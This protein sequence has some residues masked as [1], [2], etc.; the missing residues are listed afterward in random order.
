[1][2]AGRLTLLVLPKRDTVPRLSPADRYRQYLKSRTWAKK[3]QIAINRS[4]GYC[5]YPECTSFGV[6]VHHLRYPKIWGQERPE[7][8]CYLCRAHHQDIHGIETEPAA[9]KVVYPILWD[10]T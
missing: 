8:I 4:G 1:M 2:A 6:D 3:R 7:D 9:E 10:W 5:E